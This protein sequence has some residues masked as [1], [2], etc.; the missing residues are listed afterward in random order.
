MSDRIDELVEE[1]YDQYG[2][3]DPFA[4][5]EH[6]GIDLHYVPF[7]NNPMGQYIK[8]TDTP[9]ILL[10]DRLENSPERYFVL[11]HELHHALEH[12]ELSGYYVFNYRS[13]SKLETEANA[14]ATT[15][16]FH[17]YLEEHQL[18]PDTSQILE[19]TYG[20]P[21]EFSELYLKL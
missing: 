4:L 14:F 5:I 18:A 7:M 6:N 12:E 3:L 10:S 13:R 8:L 11:T 17:Y 20:V 1:L 2:T 19:F 15:L 16:L 21:S 9:T